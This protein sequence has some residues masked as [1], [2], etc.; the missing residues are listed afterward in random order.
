MANTIFDDMI[1]SESGRFVIGKVNDNDKIELLTEQQFSFSTGSKRLQEVVKEL[2]DTGVAVKVRYIPE[3]HVYS[4]T[5]DGLEPAQYFCCPVEVLGIEPIEPPAKESVE[6]FK[7]RMA[8][9]RA[10]K[11]K[12]DPKDKPIKRKRSEGSLTHD[13]LQAGPDSGPAESDG[14]GEDV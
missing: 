1:R 4:V 7:E 9:A 12:G 6:V 13:E 5:N 2:R 10:A 11:S 3:I 8:K 14:E